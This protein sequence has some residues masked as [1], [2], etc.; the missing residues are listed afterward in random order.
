MISVNQ[1]SNLISL[2]TAIETFFFWLCYRHLYKLDM[3]DKQEEESYGYGRVNNVLS[4]K[5]QLQVNSLLKNEILVT[6]YIK[7]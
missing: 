3:E 7:T 4:D 1:I 2:R 6:R 5:C